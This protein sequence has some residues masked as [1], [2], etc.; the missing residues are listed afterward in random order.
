MGV[1]LRRIVVGWLLGEEAGSE[2]CSTWEGERGRE[3][4]GGREVKWRDREREGGREREEEGRG[5]EKGV[6]EKNERTG[7]K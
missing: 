3:R 7:L 6:R 2:H 1:A 5:K 4:K